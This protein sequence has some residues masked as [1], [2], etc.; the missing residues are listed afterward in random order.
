MR[1]LAFLA[2][3]GLCACRTAA[4]EPASVLHC[5]N[6]DVVE[7]GY[8]ADMAVV[9]YKGRR[10]VMHTAISGSG[11]R[12]VGGG[13]QWWTKGFDEGTIAPLKPGEQVASAEPVVCRSG[14]PPPEPPGVVRQ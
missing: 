10:Y 6:G 12:Y 14:P 9:R 8:A 3:L 7:V 1:I 11:A 5:E 4:S 13:M 2:A